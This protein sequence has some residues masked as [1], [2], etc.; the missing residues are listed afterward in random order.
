MSI[1]ITLEAFYM[2]TWA[3]CL[4]LIYWLVGWEAQG[5]FVKFSINIIQRNPGVSP[6][7]VLGRKVE[8]VVM[9][10]G[11]VKVG[12]GGEEPLRD[13]HGRWEKIPIAI[14]FY[15]IYFNWSI[16]AL[17]NSVIFCQSPMVIIKSSSVVSWLKAG[18]WTSTD[19]GLF[20]LCCYH[21]EIWTS[22]NGS[23]PIL[24]A[25]KWGI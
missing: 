14:I 1:Y 16:I 3:R 22:S 20:W 15:F 13:P 6:L 4:G 5:A 9:E 7:W 8:V 25:V 12:N 19:L 2:L 18:L 21:L 17:Q 11:V 23:G 24:L 10:A